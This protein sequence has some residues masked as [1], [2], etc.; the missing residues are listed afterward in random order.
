MRK[1]LL[2]VL[3]LAV[4][5]SCGKKDPVPPGV[6]PP[7]KMQA[8]LWDLMRADQFLGDYVLNKDTSLNKV[9]ES[10]RYY[11]QI[12]ALHK[13][14]KE[15]FEKSFT[16]YQQHPQQFR[17]LMDSIAA[18]PKEAPPLAVPDKDTAVTEITAPVSDTSAKAPAAVTPQRDSLKPKRRV[19]KV[20]GD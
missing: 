17:A 6:L 19:Q 14:S 13:I 5:S 8:V 2:P 4:L 9:N 15:E 16:W 1:L 12:F 11:R 18:P 20:A 7:P 10:L 3:L